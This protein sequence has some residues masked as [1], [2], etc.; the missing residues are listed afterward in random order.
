MHTVPVEWSTG[1]WTSTQVSREGDVAIYLQR[2]REGPCV[3]AVRFEVIVVQHLG[4]KRMSVGVSVQRGCGIRVHRS[5]VALAGPSPRWKRH[6][7]MPG[8]WQALVSRHMLQGVRYFYRGWRLPR[9][10]TP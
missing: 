3:R 5:G 2:H 4:E 6:T 10:P 7:R 1:S 9:W 8:L